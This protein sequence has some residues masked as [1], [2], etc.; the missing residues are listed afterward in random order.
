MSP[1]PAKI[2]DFLS[3]A[4]PRST[5]SWILQFVVG[6]AAS[7]ACKTR[8]RRHRKRLREL[9]R[10]VAHSP[11]AV[12]DRSALLGRHDL[13]LRLGLH[14]R[15][16]PRRR[17]SR[18]SNPWSHRNVPARAHRVQPACVDRHPTGLF[19]SPL[20]RLHRQLA[21]ARLGKQ[22]AGTGSESARRPPGPGAAHP[23]RPLASTALGIVRLLFLL[24]R[25]AA[26]RRIDRPR[27]GAS[28]SP[29]EPGAQR[30]AAGRNGRRWDVDRRAGERRAPGTGKASSSSAGDRGRRLRRG[31]PS[32]VASIRIDRRLPR[33]APVALVAI[34]NEAENLLRPFDHRRGAGAAQRPRIGPPQHP[35]EGRPRGAR[36]LLIDQ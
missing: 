18:S 9:A 19:G 5:P 28:R 21:A 16:R 25:P 20:R 27:R 36:R 2:G 22:P 4:S 14:P 11:V 31:R 6:S 29:A 17:T 8:L 12:S 3:T 35:A 30:D 33:R 7:S 34:E 23:S 10:R 24:P 1:S 26:G 15:C 13:Q 32:P